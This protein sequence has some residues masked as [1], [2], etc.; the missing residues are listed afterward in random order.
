M[1][2]RQSKKGSPCDTVDLREAWT[3]DWVSGVGMY[4]K[5]TRVRGRG[6]ITIY[7]A[8]T[9]QGLEPRRWLDIFLT[10]L[11]PPHLHNSEEKLTHHGRR[12]RQESW[13]REE[14]RSVAAERPE[15]GIPPQT[16][17]PV[18]QKARTSEDIFCSFF[19]LS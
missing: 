6:S 2:S 15:G 17:S 11:L 5:Q 3:P 10:P 8:A 9:G 4:E 12:E 7:Q 18:P 13:Q 14:G 19:L 16:S 1:H